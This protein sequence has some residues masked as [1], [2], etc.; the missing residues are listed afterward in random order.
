M[1][2]WREHPEAGREAYEAAVWYADREL[3]LAERFARELQ[4]SLLL[5]REWPGSAPPHREVE[6]TPPIRSKRVP[7]AW[8]P[9]GVGHRRGQVAAPLTFGSMLSVSAY[10]RAPV[11]SAWPLGDRRCGPV[12]RKKKPWSDPFPH[13]E[14]AQARHC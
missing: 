3:G 14:P 7:H 13:A 2:S 11:M 4:E 12:C 9:A 8:P 6:R 1:L 5:I 10:E